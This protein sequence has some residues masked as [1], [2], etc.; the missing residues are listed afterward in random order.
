MN[1][2]IILSAITHLFSAN[3]SGTDITVSGTDIT[4]SRTDINVSGTDITVYIYVNSPYKTRDLS[5]N[6]KA[7]K[8]MN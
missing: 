2:A 5:H 1:I 7:I 8:T 6:M 4:V 3:V